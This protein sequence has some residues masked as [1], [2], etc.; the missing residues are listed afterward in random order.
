MGYFV[1]IKQFLKIF[2]SDVVRYSL[3]IKILV[4]EASAE[5]YD[6]DSDTLTFCP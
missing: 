4:L 6:F 1:E 2:D 3:N 5:W